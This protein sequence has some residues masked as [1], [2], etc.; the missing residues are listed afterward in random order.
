MPALPEKNLI[1][2]FHCYDPF[3]FTHQGAEWIDEIPKDLNDMPFPSSPEAMEKIRSKNDS[4]YAGT[5]DDYGKHRYDAAYLLSRLKIA[6]DWGE[7]HGVP[8]VLGE[9]GAY[10]KVSAPD[11]RGRWFDGMR[12]AISNLKLP[13][14]I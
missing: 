5:L 8:V 6:K 10:P 14:A 4:K 2:T 7:A 11:S 13:N 12:A 3:F 1:Y 9:F